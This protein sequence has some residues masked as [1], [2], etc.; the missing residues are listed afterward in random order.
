MHSTHFGRLLLLVTIFV[1]LSLASF[2]D[3][4]ISVTVAPPP[5]PV[6]V[7]PVCPGPGY[8]W[9]PGYWAWSDEGYYWVPGT[10]VP[11]PAV[12]LLWTPGYWGWSNG[13]YVWNP[14]Y[15]GPHIGFYGGVDYGFGYT[16]VG[17]VGGEWRSGAF[18]YNSAV[19]NVRGAH[20]TNV[21]VNKTVIVHNVNRVSYN[22]GAGGLRAAPTPA[23][24]AAMHEHHVER[25]A[26]QTQQA[27]AARRNPKLLAR[28]NGGKPVIAATA[29]PA[30]FSGRNVVP[31]R[32]AG[33]RVAPATLHAT[34]KSMPAAPKGGAPAPHAPAKTAAP[35][36]SPAPRSAAAPRSTNAA[37]PPAAR[38][39]PSTPSHAAPPARASTPPAHAAPSPRP[40]AP[41]RAAPPAHAAPQ[42]HA[43]QA[44]AAPP[45]HSNAPPPSRPQKEE[46]K[47]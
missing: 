29:K 39:R 36:P 24:Q 16:G 40:S 42:P 34:A 31:A 7:Q 6:Y 20:I 13:F 8:M 45:S 1:T 10:W 41:R 43:P 27:D 14:G 47:K 4:A 23:Q 26:L 25:T 44:H 32:A 2:A 19:M 3:V 17:F 35:R 46:Q 18:F 22:G 11:A 15:W 21:Y 9:T 33:G 38:T 5:L 28:N 12:G 30:D 37:R